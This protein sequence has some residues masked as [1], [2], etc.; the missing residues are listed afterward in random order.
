MYDTG[1]FEI[2]QP[3]TA[4]GIFRINIFIFSEPSLN[5]SMTRSMDNYW[6]PGACNAWM[7]FVYL[8]PTKEKIAAA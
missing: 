8:C 3:K 7:S 5:F 4:F 2:G 1:K 6:P